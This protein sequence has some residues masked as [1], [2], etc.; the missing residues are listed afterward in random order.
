MV[1]SSIL[2]VLTGLLMS[3][4]AAAQTASLEPKV[5]F[6]R[7]FSWGMLTDDD[8]AKRF[9]EIGVTDIRVA[10]QEQLA[11]ARKYGMTPYCGTFVACGPHR[12]IMTP[13]EEKHFSY[14]NGHDLIDLDRAARKVVLHDRRLEMQ[15]RYGGEPVAALDT[16]NSTRI[17][18]FNSDE[19][20]RLSK[21]AIDAICSRVDGVQG[22]FFDYIGYTNF[23]G[24]YCANCLAAYQSY[25][26]K[27]GAADTQKQKQI[28]Y[29]DR[30][31]TYYNDMID[32][33]KSRHPD[34]RVVVHVYPT[35]LPEPLYGNRL[36]AD[37]CGQTVAWY[38]PWST[39]K[40]AEHTQITV[41]DQNK[42]FKGVRGVPFV[43]LNQ[44][45][46]SLWIKDASTLE[47]ELRTILSAGGDMLMVCNGKDMIKPGIYDVFRKYCGDA[48]TLRD[49]SGDKR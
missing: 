22:I 7:V 14:I 48:V 39:E 4:S 49:A 31:V 33:V 21:K 47:A 11:R 15:H 43:G 36:K 40:I 37:F 46:G 6:R 27:S 23:R 9:K 25:L 41:R 19:G 2:L 5:H 44:R 8:T 38:F 32:Y 26:A 18:C 3:V 29:R 17:H 35:F 1:K 34:F 42:Y 20:Y 45:P 24:C 13:E 16:L 28:F 12:Q 30:L 10:N